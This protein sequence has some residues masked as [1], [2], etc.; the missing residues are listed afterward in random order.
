M[1]QNYSHFSRNLQLGELSGLPR[2]P[3]LVRPDS[4]ELGKFLVK[5]NKETEKDS[6][7]QWP[8]NYSQKKKIHPLEITSR[9]QLYLSFRPREAAKPEPTMTNDPLPCHWPWPSKGIPGELVN[10]LLKSS[11]ETSPKTARETEKP[12]DKGP[13]MCTLQPEPF[14]FPSSPPTSFFPGTCLL[15][16]SRVYNPWPAG[17]MQPRMS[18]NVA[19]HK[20]V[21]L[22][23]TTVF[24]SSVFIGV[25]IFNVWPKTTFLPAWPR[26]AKRLDTPAGS[27]QFVP[28]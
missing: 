27:G 12:Q 28:G 1:C 17:R 21:N 18:V 11:P 3:L 4:K 10:I 14:P 2:V 5:L 19:Q 16:A 23:K 22:L 25:C 7:T 24:C 20:I 15:N 13:S 6:W 26:D 9:P 8:S